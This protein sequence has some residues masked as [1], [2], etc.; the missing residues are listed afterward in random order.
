MSFLFQA[1][2][3]S[4]PTAILEEIYSLL[5]ITGHVLADEGEG[6]LPLVHSCYVTSHALLLMLF[7]EKFLH[8]PLCYVLFCMVD[9]FFSYKKY[10]VFISMT[11]L[12]FWPSICV[13]S[14]NGCLLISSNTFIWSMTTTRRL[15]YVCGKRFFFYVPPGSQLSSKSIY[16][17]SLLIY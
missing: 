6:E 10:I 7:F 1:R 5:L 15:L 16:Y 9:N 13:F 2:G 17:W 14:W 8:G 11:I 12:T 4:D 3:R